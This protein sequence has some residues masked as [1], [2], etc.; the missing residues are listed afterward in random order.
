MNKK[1]Y[2]APVIKKIHLEIKNAVLSVCHSSMVG[3]DKDA[4]GGCRVSTACIYGSPL[5]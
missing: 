2:T 3:D 5:P 4:A 1:T